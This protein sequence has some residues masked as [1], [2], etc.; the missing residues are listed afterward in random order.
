MTTKEHFDI[1]YARLDQMAQHLN[2]VDGRLG[3]VETPKAGWA[4]RVAF[5]ISNNKS[6]AALIAIL[7]IL[8]AILGIFASPVF[9]YW[10]EHRNDAVEDEVK[11]VLSAPGGVFDSLG[12]VQGKADAATTSLDDLKPFI[13]DVIAHQFE[14]ASE[15]STDALVKHI[16]A[17]Q[18]LA[19][20]ALDQKIAV[21]S[22]QAQALGEKMAQLANASTVAPALWS[23]SSAVANYRAEL[24]NGKFFP[25]R[26]L[27]DCSKVQP[28][29]TSNF[30][31]ITR[32]DHGAV[33]ITPWVF[34][35][36]V[37]YLDKMDA[38]YD[39]LPHFETQGD[40]VR[41]IPKIRM[42]APY[43]FDSVIV[44]YRGGPI[45]NMAITFKT[46]LFLFDI[47]QEPERASRD[48]LLAVLRDPTERAI[49]LAANE[50]APRG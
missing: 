29:Q 15:L 42:G 2:R 7:A 49:V 1:I 19:R 35:N 41:G 50:S 36:C 4:A 13:H 5:W 45:M 25:M 31:A 16:P 11:K 22:P 48:L 39:S 43:E 33:D 21:P 46:C 40:P 47:Q 26:T 32:K 12:R 8:V 44:V 38:I 27:P 28:T 17:V 37:L 10:L 9:G 14:K 6:A 34:K 23:A 20:A 30:E 24:E 18:H 3:I